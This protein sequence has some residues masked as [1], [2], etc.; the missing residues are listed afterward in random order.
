M[1]IYVIN[2]IL[3]HT[4]FF[5]HL[6]DIEPGTRVLE[7][8]ELFLY[9]DKDETDE[10]SFDTFKMTCFLQFH[11]IYKIPHFGIIRCEKLSLFENFRNF[12]FFFE[13]LVFVVL[14]RLHV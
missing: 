13:I 9:N 4:Y 14:A 12:R 10:V 1:K 5:D 6:E 3:R 11:S 2:S 8:P 7:V